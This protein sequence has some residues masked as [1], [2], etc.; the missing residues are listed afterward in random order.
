MSVGH[1]LDY[2]LVEGAHPIEGGATPGQVFLGYLQK[3]AEQESAAPVLPWSLLQFLL[4]L[5]GAPALASVSDGETCESSKP[6]W[7]CFKLLPF[8]IIMYYFPPF[9]PASKSSHTCLLAVFQIH[10]LFSH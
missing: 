2:T 7:V 8:E 5:S 4:F 6:F 9:S 10:G 1:F 3:L